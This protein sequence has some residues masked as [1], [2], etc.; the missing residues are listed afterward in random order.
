MRRFRVSERSI[1][2]LH[3]FLVIVFAV[4]VRL[5]YWADA[6]AY[7]LSGDEPDY[8]VPAQ[9]LVRDG[10][11]VDTFLSRQ[12]SWTRVPLA[13]L[14][15]AGS[16]LFVPD[17]A[18][19][20]AEGDDAAL[21]EPRYD[22][23]NLAQI[24]VSLATVALT[25][26]F[27]ARA[28]PSKA[29]RAAIVAGYIAA[30]YPP[31]ASSPA[32]R[33]LSEPLSIT[34]L[35]AA[36]YI[37]SLW[38]PDMSRRRSLAVVAGAGVLFGVAS[39]ARSVAIGFLP[40][41]WLW[42]FIVYR[43]AH[44]SDMGAELEGKPGLWVR[45]VRW[46][47]SQRKPLAAS[48]ITTMACL[49]AI[50]PWTFYNYVQYRSFL[51]LETANA[52]AYWNYHN[53]RDEDY[54]ARLS[55]LPDPADRLSL[56]I[57]EG[58]ANIL[59]Y[60]DKALGSAIFAFGYFWHLESNSAVLLNNWDMTQHDPDV[61]DLLHSDVALLLVGLAGLAGLAGVGLRRPSDDAGRVLLLLNLWFLYM[62]LLGIVVPYD[63][64]YRL[65]VVPSLI[66][67]AAGLIV[68]VDWRIVFSPRRSWAAL[69][70]HNKVAVAAL[71]LS[72]WVLVGAYTPNI[73]P[74]L[75][76]VYQ[77][78]RGDLALQSGDSASAFGRYDLAQSAFPT[79]YWPYRHQADVARGLRRDDQARTLYAEAWERN[80]DDAYG[81][82]GF[83]D[84]YA[85]HP[86]WNLTADERNW[87]RRDEG[88]W[89]GNPWNSFVPSPIT[90]IDVGS[91]GD[92]P[93]IRGFYKPDHA[94]D[95]DYRWSEGRATIRIPVPQ[96]QSF[97]TI[98]MRMSAPGIGPPE[99][100]PVRISV[101]GGSTMALEVPAGW[102]DYRLQLPKGAGTGGKTLVLELESPRR[103]PRLLQPGSNDPRDLGVGIDRITLSESAR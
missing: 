36:L 98:N 62:V 52:T 17:R 10:R 86:D 63:G 78:W 103:S 3:L 24:L 90:N 23:L 69:R 58:T 26:R 6:R 100:M 14:L 19:S 46:L 61:P 18:A 95:F 65:P 92:I 34:L 48:A 73:P 49:L 30:L 40:F 8:V 20:L 88:D 102:A 80:R 15:F 68:L 13:Q 89:R 45:V 21:M 93:Y 99:A 54:F 29:R 31:L 71:V 75:R 91:G 101:S 41:A 87:L 47:R 33:A 81:I 37:I 55:K 77:A 74:L 11:Y 4:A 1:F 79:F 64:R 57:K 85:R 96:G 60:P 2:A 43:S 84:L 56:I 59:E 76:S 72:L 70:R 66:V 28:F 53:F 27:A 97:D 83:A 42:L 94:P 35:L 38:T 7:S 9:T 5:A 12:R 50:A 51:L 67:L 22:A 32:Q 44:K 82:L 16:F 25:M 39:L